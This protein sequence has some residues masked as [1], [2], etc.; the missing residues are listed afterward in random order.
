MDKDAS[1]QNVRE[2]QSLGNKTRLGNEPFYS[3]ALRVVEILEFMEGGLNFCETSLHDDRHKYRIDMSKYTYKI[4]YCT[5]YFWILD[6]T[7]SLSS[8]IYQTTS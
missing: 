6:R 8:P 3:L 2:N 7:L 5:I 4:T 1:P